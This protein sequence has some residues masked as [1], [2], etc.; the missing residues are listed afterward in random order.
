M[1]IVPE[2]R[3]AVS[4]IR[5][6]LAEPIELPDPEVDLKVGLAPLT[7]LDTPIR[8]PTEV[9]AHLQSWLFFGLLARILGDR[10]LL[11]DFITHSPECRFSLRNLDAL[12]HDIDLDQHSLDLQH[13]VD[14]IREMEALGHLKESPA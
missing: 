2:P 6:P 11:E 10:F 3:D 4:E 7:S 1:D 9:A 8:N 14:T 12:L 13:A 5:V